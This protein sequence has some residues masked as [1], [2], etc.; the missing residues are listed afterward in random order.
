MRLSTPSSAA[1]FAGDGTVLL[2]SSESRF[3]ARAGA[4][5]RF[6]DTVGGVRKAAL[7]QRRAGRRGRDGCIVLGSCWVM[8]DVPAAGAAAGSAAAAVGDTFNL[9]NN[10]Q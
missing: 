8:C 9:A 4:R 5:G 3:F 1:C 10:I 7:V 6:R 2:L